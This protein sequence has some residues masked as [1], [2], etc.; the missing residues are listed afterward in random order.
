MQVRIHPIIRGSG[1]DELM[2]T[3]LEIQSLAVSEDYLYVGSIELTWI[4][5]RF[6]V[7]GYQMRM[8]PEELTSFRQKRQKEGRICNVALGYD[9]STSEC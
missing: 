6:W 3:D 1:L 5:D 8:A 9:A 4:F 7:V 2:K